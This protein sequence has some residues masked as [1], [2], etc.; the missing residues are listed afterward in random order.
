[1]LDKHTKKR[2]V[3]LNVGRFFENV[4]ESHHKRQDFLLDSFAKMTDLHNEWEL[5]FAGSVAENA[6]S[7]KYILSLMKDAK[8]MPVVFHFNS[9]FKELRQLF[10]E[11]TIYWHATGYGSD[12]SK[13]PEKQEHFGI[14]TIEAMSTGAIPVVINTAGQTET[15]TNEVDG[16][17]WNNFSELK[18]KTKFVATID[19]K[20]LSVLQDSSIKSA[21]HFQLNAFRKNAKN[22]F[23]EI[24]RNFMLCSTHFT[25]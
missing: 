4:G 18:Q 24:F 3:I 2:K 21:Q 23:S 22:I 10:N 25:H 14:T 15:I 5:H 17:L 7:L 12:V 11:A 13:H 19:K 1:M 9:S 8:S 6:G 16:F 20:D